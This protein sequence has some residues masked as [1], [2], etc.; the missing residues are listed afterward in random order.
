MP[1]KIFWEPAGV[2]LKWYGKCTYQENLDAN[3]KLYGD[4]RFESIRYQI[5]D[6]VDADT[7]EF[8]DNN[9]KIIAKL[10]SK[11]VIWN[12][13]LLVAHVTNDEKLI[14]Q[15]NLYEEI[16]NDSNWKFGIFGNLEEARKW[17]ESEI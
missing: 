17:I 5:S 10:E 8:T 13:H 7:S 15:I 4:K 3:G 11:A 2:L 1:Y 12:K 9:V 16:M 6:V 14:R